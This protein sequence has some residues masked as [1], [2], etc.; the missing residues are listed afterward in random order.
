MRIMKKLLPIVLLLL[1][2][3]LLWAG[4]EKGITAN[5]ISTFVDVRDGEVYHQVTIGSQTWMADNLRYN[6]PGSWV[7]PNNPS[8]TY[9]RLYDWVTAQT[10][11]PN[12][13]HLPS[14]AEWTT[15]E[16]SLGLNSSDAAST[17]FRGTHEAS[18]KSTTGWGSGNG[19]NISGFNA[20]PA[21]E[22]YLGSFIGLNDY[23]AFWSSTE[24]SAT[25][26]W[27]RAL[28]NGYMGMD[29]DNFN[30]SPG[31]SCRCIKD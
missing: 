7:N 24:Y 5:H 13:W 17:G 4:C 10:A 11:C 31:S 22:Y 21:G 12:G 14:D 15:L 16:I 23:T 18:I 20:L 2:L 19:T 1:S 9:G 29:R 8:S 3:M 6:S 27:Y 28:R 25:R 26:A 30:K